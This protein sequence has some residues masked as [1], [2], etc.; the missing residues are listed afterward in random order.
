MLNLA[1]TLLIFQINALTNFTKILFHFLKNFSHVIYPL[2]KNNYDL[3]LTVD[4]EEKEQI[5]KKLLVNGY[6]GTLVIASN[7]A[8]VAS[9]CDQVLVLE[10]GK[11]KQ[12]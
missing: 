5:I 9:L 8:T 12:E 11:L 7:D 10:K 4:D 3:L 2:R 6:Q 1:H